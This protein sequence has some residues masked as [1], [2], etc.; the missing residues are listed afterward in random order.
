MFKRQGSS[1]VSVIKTHQMS[2][3]DVICEHGLP[4]IC[5]HHLEQLSTIL[6]LSICA[7]MWLWIFLYWHTH[8]IWSLEISPRV[9]GSIPQSFPH[10]VQATT[11]Q[12][13]PILLAKRN[14]KHCFP[15]R[16]P[17]AEPRDSTAE[18]H[19]FYLQRPKARAETKEEKQSGGSAQTSLVSGLL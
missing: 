18:H 1:E 8:N 19:T 4:L 2:S 14:D 9:T 11:S 6:M 15:V 16:I 13:N 10:L 3:S 5:W 7:F 12:G 17:S